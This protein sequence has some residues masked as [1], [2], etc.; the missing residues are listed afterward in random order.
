V[1]AGPLMVIISG[2]AFGGGAMSRFHALPLLLL[3]ALIV[4][5]LAHAQPAPAAGEM[6]PAQPLEPWQRKK[7]PTDVILV[8]GAMPSASDSSTPLPEGGAVAKDFYRNSYFGLSYAL[9]GGWVEKHKGPPPSE[10]GAY[11]LTL[12]RPG[13]AYH[14][15]SRAT[16]L[17]TA[18]DLF[19]N[20]NP[21]HNAEET[22]QLAKETLENSYSVEQPPARVTIAGHPFARFDYTSPVAQLHWHMLATEIRCHAIRFV[23]TGPDPEVIESLIKDMDGMKLPADADAAAGTGGTDSPSCVARYAEGSN[24]LFKVEPQFNDHKFNPIPVRIIIDKRGKVRHVHVISAFAEQSR[25]ITDA[26]IQWRF[27]PYLRDGQPAEVETGIL[28]GEG[29]NATKSAVARVPPATKSTD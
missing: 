6:S 1:K 29:S 22:I 24:V 16:L 17:I 14:G 15:T 18:Q 2:L 13:P 27:K 11:V 5:G 10:S 3:S 21:A 9:P 8:N 23:F 4:P 12:L 19:F 7:V 25:A 26:L 28:F 20:R